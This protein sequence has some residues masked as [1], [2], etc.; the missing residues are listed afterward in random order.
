MTNSLCTYIHHN[1]CLPKHTHP[2]Q[3]KNPAWNT[4]KG[5]YVLHQGPQRVPTV[6][7]RPKKTYLSV[8]TCTWGT[9]PALWQAVRSRARQTTP[10]SW[11]EWSETLS[12]EREARKWTGRG[13]R[14]GEFE[15]GREEGRVRQKGRASTGRKGKKTYQVQLAV[16]GGFGVLCG[17][18]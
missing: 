10:W 11:G 12:A 9:H 18:A 17:I 3:D 4:A 8:E 16:Q 13:K 14:K 7:E 1:I 6:S 15:E 5:H 2:P